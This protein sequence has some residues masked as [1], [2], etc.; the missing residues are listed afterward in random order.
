MAA[1]KRLVKDEIIVGIL[2]FRILLI[3]KGFSSL[4]HGPEG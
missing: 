1:T 2:G 3:L 4:N